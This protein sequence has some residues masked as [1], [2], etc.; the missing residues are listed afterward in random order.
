MFKFEKLSLPPP[1]TAEAKELKISVEPP[2]SVE[3][4]EV[5]SVG[6]ELVGHDDLPIT[7]GADAC[8]L[9]ELSMPYQE[10]VLSFYGYET[11]WNM[12]Y[13]EKVS[14]NPLNQIECWVIF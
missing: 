1:I 5:F 4:Q 3:A 2:A 11:M 8:A 10:D 6:V 12:L 13:Y 9:V 7:T 14:L